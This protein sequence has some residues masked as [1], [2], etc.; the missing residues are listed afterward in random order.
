MKKLK[1][2]ANYPTTGYL[3]IIHTWSFSESKGFKVYQYPSTTSMDYLKKEGLALSNTQDRFLTSD[4][5]I[6]SLNDKSQYDS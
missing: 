4:F 6:I 5:K 1:V 2:E 3:L